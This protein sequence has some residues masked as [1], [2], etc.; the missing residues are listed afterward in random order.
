MLL[1]SCSSR[2][3]DAADGQHVLDDGDH[4]LVAPHRHCVLR[5]GKSCW[6]VSKHATHLAPSPSF[7]PALSSEHSE[8]VDVPRFSQGSFADSRS[9]GLGQLYIK[10]QLSLKRERS[11]AKV[12]DT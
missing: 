2:W 3:W 12:G 7:S 8:L 1:T 11:N 9:A 10:A 6:R 5:S 4:V